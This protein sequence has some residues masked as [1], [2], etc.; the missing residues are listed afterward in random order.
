MFGLFRKGIALDLGTVNT[1]IWDA[2]EGLLLKEPS[3][4]AR[5]HESGEVLAVGQKAR[6]FWGKTPPDIEVIK[7]LKEGAVADFEA[8]RAMIEEFL[9]KAR[10]AGGRLRRVLVVASMCLRPVEK[11]ALSQV[12][13]EAGAGRALVVEEPLAA[14]VGAGLDIFARRSQMILCLGGGTTQLAVFSAGEIIFE[15][16]VRVAGNSLTENVINYLWRKYR[17]LVGEPTAEELKIRL[18]AATPQNEPL[19]ETISG[20]DSSG[21]PKTAEVTEED[22]REAIRHGLEDIA[23]TVENAFSEM[24]AGFAREAKEAGII[25]TGGGALIRGIKEFLEDRIK[26]PVAVAAEPLEAPARGGALILEKTK[27]YREFIY[28]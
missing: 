26:T 28:R 12:V 8:C 11:K 25:L 3:L 14:A 27:P 16:C 23:L 9:E 4:V 19:L 18:A 7:P 10:E 15:D 6:K 22:I 5:H 1:T 24:P 2:K 21:I 13:E 20:K 17:L